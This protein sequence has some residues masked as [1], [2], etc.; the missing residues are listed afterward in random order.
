[1]SRVL[2]INGSPH[3]AGCTY[4]ALRE[5]ADTLEKNG[6]GDYTDIELFIRVFDRDDWAADP[7]GEGRVHIYPLGEENATTFVREED[8]GKQRRGS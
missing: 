3:K 5:V 6:V 7:V 8:F 4:T 1:M 2:L